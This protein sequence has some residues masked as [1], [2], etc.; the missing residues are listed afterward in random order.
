MQKEVQCLLV[1]NAKEVVGMSHSGQE[2]GSGQLRHLVSSRL[3]SL[4]TTP[5]V[6][7]WGG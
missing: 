1:G 2:G 7:K 6:S 3:V 4:Q 5:Q